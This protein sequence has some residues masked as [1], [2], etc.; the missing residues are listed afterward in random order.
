MEAGQ[1]AGAAILLGTIFVLNP[2][3]AVGCV[4]GAAFFMLHQ[5]HHKPLARVA[6][7]LISMVA[8]YGV[9]VGYGGE[10]S[11][12]VAVCGGAA[13]VVVLSAAIDRVQS[14]EGGA[15][16]VGFLLDILRGKR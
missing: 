12:F 13:S 8:G 3:A 11:L 9:G 10:W 7:G 15:G 4:F 1:A 14:G 2:D 16:L 6:Y 5:N